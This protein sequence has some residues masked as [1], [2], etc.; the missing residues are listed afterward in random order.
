MKRLS[1]P[2][3]L[4]CLPTL[5]ACSGAPAETKPPA[6]Q[7]ST[8]FVMAGYGVVLSTH[9]DGTKSS[10]PEELT[11]AYFDGLAYGKGRLV[12]LGDQGDVVL[13]DDFGATYFAPGGTSGV[14][15][16]ELHFRRDE[17]IA[18]GTDLDPAAPAT[19]AL[20]VHSEDGSTWTAMAPPL[21]GGY[22]EAFD[23]SD[24]A[25]VAVLAGDTSG[26]LHRYT[27]AAGWQQVSP[28]GGPKYRDVF[29]DNGTFLA[30]A[31]S[32][33]AT[34]RGALARSSDDGLT[35]EVSDMEDGFVSISKES[36]K[37]IASGFKKVAVSDDASSWQIHEFEAPSTRPE[38]AQSWYFYK[39]AYD[40]CQFLAVGGLH[41]WTAKS[42]D[43][44]TWTDELGPTH[45]NLLEVIHIPGE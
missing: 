4:G 16:Y 33:P 18:V 14:E 41:G 39:M 44:S 7:C 40:G 19:R 2:I 5:T 17:F 37:Y 8:H 43:G 3:L 42:T 23:A 15:S 27:D 30:I 13:S 38:D 24:T 34:G 9:P 11:N 35:F 10:A 31:T 32:D 25:I 20:C 12:A 29:Y 45:G 28:A 22:F 26:T 6:P 36:G 1:L 21:D